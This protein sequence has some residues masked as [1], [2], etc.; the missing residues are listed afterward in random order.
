MPLLYWAYRYIGVIFGVFLDYYKRSVSRKYL[1]DLAC[2]ITNHVTPLLLRESSS[3]SINALKNDFEVKEMQKIP[4]VSAVGSLMY[5]Q[6][7]MLLD[8]MYIVGILGRS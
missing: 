4:Y 3:V 1:R 7:C 5:A 2:R 8:I 6:V